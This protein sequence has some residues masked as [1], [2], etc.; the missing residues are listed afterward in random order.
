MGGVNL[1]KHLPAMSLLLSVFYHL[2]SNVYTTIVYL[3]NLT[4]FDSP[5]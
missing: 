2:K 4:C 1:L 5:V 3:K